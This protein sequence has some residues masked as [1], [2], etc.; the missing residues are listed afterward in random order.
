MTSDRFSWRRVAQLFTFWWPRLRTEFWIFLAYSAVASVAAA[1]ID[2]STGSIYG[3]T[4]AGPCSY[5]AMLGRA[6]FG[7]K[8]GREERIALPALNSEKMAFLLIYS[9]LVLPLVTIGVANLVYGAICG[10]T[11]SIQL[12]KSHLQG[13]PGTTDADIVRMIWYNVAMICAITMTTLYFSTASRRR[14][15]WRGVLLGLCVYIV[16]SF[17]AG[18]VAGVAGAKAGFEAAASGAA[19]DVNSEMFHQQL[20]GEVMEVMGWFM[21]A[22]IFISVIWLG[23]MLY[24]FLRN[25]PKRQD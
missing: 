5:M 6:I 17:I 2:K 7:I 3:S 20:V 18:M 15:V 25:F 23:I 8:A 24:L 14:G 12:M 1:L 13:V 21:T 22:M 19:A 16:P 4:L 11:S 10:W 9:F